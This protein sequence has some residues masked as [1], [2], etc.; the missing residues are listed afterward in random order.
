MLS[1]RWCFFRTKT[2]HEDVCLGMIVGFVFANLALVY[3]RLH[4]RVIHRSVNQ[5]AALVMINPRIT[6]MHPVTFATWVDQKCC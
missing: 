4:I 3:Q 2:A 6:S 1:N 5:L